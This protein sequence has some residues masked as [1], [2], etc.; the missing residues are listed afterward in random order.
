MNEKSAL[1]GLHN[2][3][4]LR[5]VSLLMQAEG[6]KV[7]KARTLDDMLQAMGVITTDSG[8]AM[9]KN[10]FTHYFMDLNLGQSAS[11]DYSPAKRVYDLVN[12]YT[13]SGEAKFLGVSANFKTVELAQKA[14]IPAELGNFKTFKKFIEQG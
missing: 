14:G 2:P 7:T 13:E 4:Y 1:V 9:P 8:S 11:L 10:L 5:Y 6:I 3:A 12:P